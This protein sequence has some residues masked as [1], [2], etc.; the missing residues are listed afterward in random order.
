MRRALRS[1]LWLSFAFAGALVPLL[2][3]LLSGRTLAWRDTAQ[4][5]APLRPTVV[6][7]LREFRLPL[8]NPWDGAGHPLFAEAMHSVLHPVSIAL[9]PFTDSVDA[10]AAALVFCAAAG[11]WVAARTLG[12][13]PPA[14]A[15]AAVGYSASGYVLS[16][17]A[18]VVYLAGA[19]SAP[20]VIGGM[21]LAATHPLGWTAS[22]GA[23]AAAALTGDAGTLATAVLAGGA[24]AAE[25]GGRR[26]LLRAMAGGVLGVGMA[27]VQVLPTLAFLPE[28]LRAATNAPVRGW[29]LAPWRVAELASPG[30]FVGIPDS[31]RAPVFVA[32][33]ADPGNAF[34]FAAS[35]FVGAPLIAL[36]FLAARDRR[37]GQVLLVLAA[38][39]LWLALGHHL[40]AQ[41]LLGHL[42]VW[43]SLRYW[44]KM[45]GPLTLF[46]ALGAG[47]GVDAATADPGRAMRLALVA[48]AVAAAGLGAVLALASNGIS[49]PAVAELARSNLRA[50]AVQSFA[51]LAG[52]A[53]ALV[54]T[55]R[56]PALVGPVLA[57][58]ILAQ[59]VAASP[60]AIHSGD[61]GVLN[62]RPPALA[63]APPGPRLVSPLGS[64]GVEP[65]GNLDA[66]DALQMLEA[67]TGRPAT[68]AAARVDN[69]QAYTGLPT[70]RWWL[71][72]ESGEAFWALTRRFGSTH[73]LSRLPESP[74]EG[75]LLGLLATGSVPVA[76][77]GSPDLRVWATAHRPWASF[78]PA[79]AVAKGPREALRAMVAE[80]ADGRPTV[81]VE[82]NAAPPVAPGQVLAVRRGDED[83][84][85]E[86][87][88]VGDALLVVNDAF[89]RGW[90]AR[91]D[92]APV[93]ILPADVL[94]RAVRWPAGRHR[95]TMRYAP[96][97]VA[98]GAAVSAL[99]VGIL[100][101]TVVWQLRRGRGARAGPGGN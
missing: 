43:G 49:D 56:R 66:I 55:R 64:A 17:T 74:E 87:E 24:L 61:P 98:W 36:A 28:T 40:G 9:A 67:R 59:S 65:R 35:V 99:S 84:E 1:W 77:P 68:N 41:Q 79:A 88:S 89:S 73:L 100:A 57:A 11:A 18:N 16:S 8:W 30:F 44:E 62:A 12:A 53:M 2:P 46:L 60:Y 32:L 71:V 96:P 27:A 69:L 13:S 63:A 51:G 5:Y 58:L 4:L 75:A 101:L 42:P 7:A 38:L 19:A 37:T 82:A 21:R 10:F 33:G 80:M 97:D 15:A 22:A 20:W 50:G 90:R 95:L 6:R 78:A 14:A 48:A 23:V 47:L 86:A 54:L 83:L 76:L 91:I 72:E 39:V 34:P 52:L 94:V 25:Q 85:V 3:V 26:G 29:A 92:G 93:E 31:Y 81:V 70:L 45:V